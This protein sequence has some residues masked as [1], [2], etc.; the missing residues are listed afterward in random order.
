MWSFKSWNNLKV[1]QAPLAQQGNSEQKKYLLLLQ[2]IFD[3]RTEID[4]K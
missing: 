2:E 4:N 1:L 3:F